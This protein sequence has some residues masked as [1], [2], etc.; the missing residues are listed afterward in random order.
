MIS[1]GRDVRC[2]GKHRKVYPCAFLPLPLLRQNC[3]D[4]GFAVRHIEY[5]KMGGG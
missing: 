5:D 1:N 3:H 2:A 4:Y